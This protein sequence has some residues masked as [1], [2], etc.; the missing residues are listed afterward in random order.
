MSDRSDGYYSSD[1]GKEKMIFS[2]EAINQLSK[3]SVDENYLTIR[4]LNLCSK[5]L[6]QTPANIYL[7]SGELFCGVCLINSLSSSKQNFEIK[8][9]IQVTIF[10][11]EAFSTFREICGEVEV[12]SSFF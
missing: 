1:E 10:I 2:K 8:P 6:P 12:A 5:C 7:E 11:K 9:S 3:S 4:D